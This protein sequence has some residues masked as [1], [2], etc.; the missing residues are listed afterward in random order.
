MKISREQKEKMIRTNVL[1]AGLYGAEACYVNKGSPKQFRSAIANVIGPASHRRCV[2]LTYVFS[3]AA[4]DLDPQVHTTYNRIAALRRRA[5]IV[6]PHRIGL[7]KIIIKKYKSLDATSRTPSQQPF[8]KW[9]LEMIGKD[10]LDEAKP[11]RPQGPVG[12]VLEDPAR[13]G[14]GLDSDLNVSDNEEVLI[15]I[16]N[17]PWQH[18][19]KAV[20][21]LVTMARDARIAEHCTSA[22]HFKGLDSDSSMSAN[23]KLR[24]KDKRVYMHIAT[25]C[26]WGEDHMQEVFA[27]KGVC[28]HCGQA[29]VNTKPVE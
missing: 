5:A 17:M 10:E 29:D 3:G 9:K 11:F 24:A 2:D 21:D 25:G 27:S 28:P 7:F 20:F 14:I 12:F 19:K 8:V 23:Q 1:P 15:N 26:F 4:K 6:G 18:L 22:G 13:A 16:W